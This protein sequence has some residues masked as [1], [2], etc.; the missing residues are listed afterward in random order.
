MP[1]ATHLT[2]ER[3]RALRDL[4]DRTLSQVP[5]TFGRIAYLAS[6][7]DHNSGRYQ[8]YGLAQVY[9]REEADEALRSS[10]LGAFAEWLTYALV[11][12]KDDLEKY[13]LS[14]EEDLKTVLEAWTGLRPYRNL[15]PAGATDAQRELFFSDLELIL[16]LLRGEL[17]P[18][19]PH[20]G[21]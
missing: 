20:P 11:R 3:S 17:S 18:V 21:A 16:E 10:H 4:W 1:E 15:I 6:L 13:L 9:S 7:R 2:T 19:E 5:T 14:L 8:H 12:Q